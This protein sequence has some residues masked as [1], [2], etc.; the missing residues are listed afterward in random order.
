M[1]AASAGQWHFP[2]PGALWLSVVL[3]RGSLET[4]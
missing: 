3:A 2:F 1:A 4:E